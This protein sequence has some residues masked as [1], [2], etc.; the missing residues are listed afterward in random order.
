MDNDYRIRIGYGYSGPSA[1]YFQRQ[2]YLTAMVSTGIGTI[3]YLD[4]YSIG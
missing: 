4:I 2:E 3:C 1:S